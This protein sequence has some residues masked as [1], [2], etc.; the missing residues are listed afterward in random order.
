MSVGLVLLMVFFLLVTGFIVFMERSQRRIPVQYAKRVVGR[1]VYGGQSPHLPLKVNTAGVIP[2]IFASSIILFYAGIAFAYFVVFELV[3]GFFASITP[4]SVEMMTDIAAY[5]DFITKIFL[6]FG[7]AFATL[8]T[9]GLAPVLYA[10]VLRVASPA[11]GARPDPPGPESALGDLAGG[12]ARPGRDGG[13]CVSR[14]STM[15]SSPANSRMSRSRP[16][17]NDGGSGTTAAFVFRIPRKPTTEAM[18]RSTCS[19]TD[20]PAP[21]P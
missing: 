10:V 13:S 4:Q 6:A 3:F 16:G 21:I 1:K 12:L 20:E 14:S 11:R 19:P 17:G 8:V 9:L 2:P 5:L 18:E 15:A 7:L